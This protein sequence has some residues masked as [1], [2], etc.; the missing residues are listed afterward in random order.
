MNGCIRAAVCSQSN[1]SGLSRADVE[2][3]DA[4][5]EAKVCSYWQRIGLSGCP[6]V[7]Q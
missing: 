4:P 3:V 6:D 1:A 7:T 2:K 5:A